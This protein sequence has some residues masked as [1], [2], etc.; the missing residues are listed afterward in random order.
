MKTSD[1]KVNG[2]Y[3]STRPGKYR[4]V[5]GIFNGKVLYAECE[6]DVRGGISPTW[7]NGVASHKAHQLWKDLKKQLPHTGSFST[8]STWKYHLVN[9]RSFA[10]WA[11]KLETV[12]SS[13][14]TRFLMACRAITVARGRSIST[15]GIPYRGERYAAH[16]L[17]SSP[18]DSVLVFV[19]DTISIAISTADGSMWIQRNE[20]HNPAVMVNEHG[21]YF[22][23]HGEWSYLENHVLNHLTEELPVLMGELG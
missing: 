5:W 22:R 4:L 3:R 9:L 6:P 2:I 18:Q 10:R 21:I 20:N 8:T 19:D 23:F 11:Y 13:E 12:R 14:H 15:G 16:Q 7:V 17:T 1:I